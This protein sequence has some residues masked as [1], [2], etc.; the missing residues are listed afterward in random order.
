LEIEE[1]VSISISHLAA[2]YQCREHDRAPRDLDQEGDL[3][4]QRFPTQIT[5]WRGEADSK[6]KMQRRVEHDLY[7]IENWSILFD[8]WILARTPFALI[9]GESAY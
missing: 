3:R 5:G 7:Y 2:D 9:R 6:E 4:E 8:L 1:T